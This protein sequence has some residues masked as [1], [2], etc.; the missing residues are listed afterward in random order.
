MTD[1]PRPAGDRRRERARE[2]AAASA[3]AGPSAARWLVPDDDGKVVAVDVVA[4]LLALDPRTRLRG[5]GDAQL[6]GF[7]ATLDRLVSAAAVAPSGRPLLDV[8]VADPG[9]RLTLAPS[10]SLDALFGGGDPRGV[11]THDRAVR[12][13]TAVLERSRAHR[14][15]N[16]DLYQEVAPVGHGRHARADEIEAVVNVANAGLEPVAG[17]DPAVV[18]HG[19]G[20]IAASPAE[21]FLAAARGLLGSGTARDVGGA[22]LA[23]WLRAA[24]SEG[25]AWWFGLTARLDV[26][27]TALLDDAA[28]QA[29][30]DHPDVLG[31]VLVQRIADRY[32]LDPTR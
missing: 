25:D 15:G 28:S 31:S 2:A 30:S 27:A 18:T 5:R 26:D 24:P 23:R 32:P 9:E 20:W 11:G 4:D 12:L 6:R 19:G 1:E 13:A 3:A 14:D 17:P 16:V 7:A 8:L 10:F 21:L 29:G 22:V